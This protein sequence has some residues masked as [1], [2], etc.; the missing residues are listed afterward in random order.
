MDCGTS[1]C[2]LAAVS[3]IFVLYECGISEIK[4]VKDN[5]EDRIIINSTISRDI[6]IFILLKNNRNELILM[7]YE[8][9]MHDSCIS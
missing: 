4:S 8:Y 6:T 3:L 9:L 2:Q 7:K 1:I 5:F